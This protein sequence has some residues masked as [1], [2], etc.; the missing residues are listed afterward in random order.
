VRFSLIAAKF[1]QPILLGTHSPTKMAAHWYPRNHMEMEEISDTIAARLK[2]ISD[3]ERF[4]A[5][6]SSG[7]RSSNRDFIDSHPNPFNPTTTI[8]YD[9]PQPAE[10]TLSVFDLLGRQIRVLASG[11]QPAGNYEVTFGAA[12]LPSGVYLV[13]LAA[14]VFTDAKT[15]VLV[16]LPVYRRRTYSGQ[17]I[18]SQS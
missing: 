13:R 12:G 8:S 10:A 4:I 14:G 18:T 7:D 2:M 9:L 1:I 6:L 16:R 15:A 11:R 17:P 3:L 5:G